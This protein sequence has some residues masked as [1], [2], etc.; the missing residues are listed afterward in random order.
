MK[1]KF[2]PK[3]VNFRLIWPAFSK[4]RNLLKKVRKVPLDTCIYMALTNFEDFCPKICLPLLKIGG[5]KNPKENNNNIFL[6]VKKYN[7]SQKYDDLNR[8]LF[9]FT[10]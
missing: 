8:F 7:F 5:T 6:A 9:K 10:L 4:I 3:K 2:W 1:L